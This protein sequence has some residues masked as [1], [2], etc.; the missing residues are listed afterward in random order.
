MEVWT[1]WEGVCVIA[2]AGEMDLTNIDRFR[3]AVDGCLDR[4]TGH[5]A[6]GLSRLTFS[7]SAAIYG[8]LRIAKAVARSGGEIVLAAAP[9]Q[10][11]EVFEIVKLG[12]AIR[13]VRSLEAALTHHLCEDESLDTTLQGRISARREAVPVGQREVAHH[14]I[15][16]R[17]HEISQSDESATDEENW[18]RAERE[19]RREPSASSPAAAAKRPLVQATVSSQTG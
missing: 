5:L 16:R 2:L 13:V 10:L 11:V 9:A 19:L 7:D 6:I 14:E 15:A 8:F 4:G 1:P 17:A 12:E 18:H 3:R